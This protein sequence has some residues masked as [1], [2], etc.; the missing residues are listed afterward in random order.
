MKGFF[1][2]L[3]ERVSRT[4]ESLKI[5]SPWVEQCILEKLLEVLPEGVSL[6]VILRVREAEDLR[7]TGAGPSVFWKNGERSFT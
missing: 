4:R 3:K 7:I 5:A 1:E 6:Q 2:L